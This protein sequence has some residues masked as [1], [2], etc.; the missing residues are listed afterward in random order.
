[1]VG[2]TINKGSRANLI[3]RVSRT[4]V[5]VERSRDSTS[6]VGAGAGFGGTADPSGKTL[7]ST[8]LGPIQ[9]RHHI[10]T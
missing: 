3:F 9:A 6:S 7:I 1:M 8:C 10:Y 5:P 2:Y 4:F